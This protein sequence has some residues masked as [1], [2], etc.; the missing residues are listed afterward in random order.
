MLKYNTEMKLTARLLS[1]LE[2]GMEIFTNGDG[3]VTTPDFF[4]GKIEALNATTISIRRSDGESGGGLN[5]AWIIRLTDNTKIRIYVPKVQEPVDKAFTEL[6][7]GDVFSIIRNGTKFIFMHLDASGNGHMRPLDQ[8][9]SPTIRMS[10]ND[11]AAPVS[12]YGRKP[13]LNCQHFGCHKPAT[14][15]QML[16][17]E[18]YFCDGHA[19]DDLQ[20]CPDCGKPTRTSYMQHFR[21][22]GRN[23]LYLCG[24]CCEKRRQADQVIKN[25][26]YKPEPR[27]IQVAPVLDG[28]R[29]KLFAGCEIEVECP[30][31]D[32][33][34]H[35]EEQTLDRLILP[36]RNRR[37]PDSL[38]N[39]LAKIVF[40]R[41]N[42]PQPWFYLKHDG[43]LDNG[44]ELVTEPASYEAHKKLL[45]WKKVLEFMKGQG[46]DSDDTST[47]GLHVHVN[48]NHMDEAHR[49]RLGY[50]V[51]SQKSKMELLARRNANDYARF[52]PA[53]TPIEDMGHNTLGGKYEALNWGPPHTVEF[54]LF[55]GTINYLRLMA[56]LELTEACI[57]YTANAE[58]EELRK[59]PQAWKDFVEFTK[60]QG[61]LYLPAYIHERGAE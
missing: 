11:F 28:L 47:C 3:S 59:K 57:L 49:I 16:P 41:F 36:T 21:V 61:L 8:P 55:R 26:S 14:K 12:F 23:V 46:I 51:N 48:K 31:P 33:D 43:S 18:Q 13:F 50:F 5:G 39:R 15:L 34:E 45:P 1:E 6:K 60:T 25:Y 19:P 4:A 22:R 53:N 44:F 40:K 54:R 20:E 24:T 37:D 7:F 2:V 58:I 52:K 9:T 42:R 30:E 35:D 17:H 10:A 29:G 27:F 56:S 32:R 38:T